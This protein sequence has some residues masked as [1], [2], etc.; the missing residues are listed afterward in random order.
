MK[1]IL[2]LIG[3][4]VGGL[5]GLIVIAIVTVITI[6]YFRFHKTYDIDVSGIKIPTDDASIARGEHLVQAV[7]HCGYCHGTDFSGDYMINNPGKEGIVVAP[8]LTSG[9]GGIGASFTN[10][11]WV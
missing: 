4:I 6:G 5:V 11:G 7:A 10:E 8:N 2:K 9:E 1:R 3:R